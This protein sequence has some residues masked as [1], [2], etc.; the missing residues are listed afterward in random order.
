MVI[1]GDIFVSLLSGQ[2]C[3]A[4]LKLMYLDCSVRLK[5]IIFIEEKLNL[6]GWVPTISCSRNS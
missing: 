6:S 2:F 5:V 3:S 1:C 4:R